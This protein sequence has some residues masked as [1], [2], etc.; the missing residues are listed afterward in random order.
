MSQP[1]AL[2]ELENDFN[3]KRYPK[4]LSRLLTRGA[5]LQKVSYL[6]L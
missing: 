3:E 4:T 5:R 6:R 2:Q 1:V